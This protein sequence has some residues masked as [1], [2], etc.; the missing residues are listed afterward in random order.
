MKK[1]LSKIFRVRYFLSALLLGTILVLILNPDYLYDKGEYFKTEYSIIGTADQ[2][3][4]LP[5]NPYFD[6]VYLKSVND[7]DDTIVNYRN[8]KTGNLSQREM[9]NLSINSKIYYDSTEKAIYIIMTRGADYYLYEL[10]NQSNPNQFEIKGYKILHYD[11]YDSLQDTV[12]IVN[13]MKFYPYRIDD[14]MEE[15]CKVTIYKDGYK[16][17][18]TK[19]ITKSKNYKY[20]NKIAAKISDTVNIKFTAFNLN[21]LIQFFNR[22]LHYHKKYF[23]KLKYKEKAFFRSHIVGKI[24][25]NN[26]GVK[27]VLIKIEGSRWINDVLICYSIDTQKIVWEKEYTQGITDFLIIDIDNDGIDEIL[28][29]SYSACL[30]MPIDTYKKNIT[31]STNHSYFSIWDNKGELKNI[32]NRPALVS[33]K[34]G[35]FQFI[36]LPLIE[37]NKVLL[38][39]HS[40]YDNTNKKIILYDIIKNKI[41]SLD[42]VYQNIISLYKENGNIVAINTLDNELKKTI[43]SGD[44]KEKKVLKKK[45]M[46][47]YEESGYCKIHGSVYSFLHYPFI[48]YNNNLKFL[49]Q[50]PKDIS[51]AYTVWKDNNL[52]FIQNKGEGENLFCKLHFE[53]NR[54]LN[55]YIIIIL[56]VEVLLIVI[57]LLIFQRIKIPLNTGTSSYFVLYTIFG[58]LYYWQL[59]GRLKTIYKLPKN[60]ALSKEIPEKIFRDIAEEIKMVCERSFLIF[61]YK[62]YEILSYDEFQI[63]Q[64]ISHDLKNQVLLAKLTME[65]FE[66]QMEESKQNK[67]H[68]LKN[69]ISSFKDISNAATILSNFSHISKLYREEID[70]KEYIELLLSKYVNHPLYDKIELE[71]KNTISVLSLDKNLF[72]I[73]FKNIINNA[74][75]AITD[76][77]YI[78]IEI[79]ET[80]ENIIIEVKNPSAYLLE[81]CEKF[82]KIGFSTKEAG[83]GLGIPISKTIIEKHNG[84]LDISLKENEFIVRIILATKNTKDH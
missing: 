49:Y 35:F 71:F 25:T 4:F 65:Q 27:E 76:K 11:I 26:D 73:A 2:F 47:R 83:S 21:E 48:I 60:V 82:Y 75:E 31:M 54:T 68:F 15:D 32:Q 23:S 63:I 70:L 66:K 14:D 40:N 80:H 17:F 51:I 74:L 28:S 61:K 44:F 36:Y 19:E 29:S 30:E 45:V 57:Y 59:H 38:G 6:V 55:P 22:N 12:I 8:I 78:K 20:Y 53:R 37:K 16:L 5:E 18:F 24:D 84:T 46:R 72:E 50:A 56:L 41:D 3:A 42:I 13:N 43:I 67:K 69:L 81:D 1:I 64:R 52:Y 7:D 58:K 62:V 34:P 79:S 10:F 33:S 77:D 39:L 9:I